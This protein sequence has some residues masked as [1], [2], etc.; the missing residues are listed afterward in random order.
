MALSDRGAQELG[1]DLSSTLCEVTCRTAG[2]SS[3]GTHLGG[4]FCRP[5]V[6]GEASGV[7]FHVNKVI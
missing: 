2:L 7:D 1:L 4:G 6:R 5:R 3:L